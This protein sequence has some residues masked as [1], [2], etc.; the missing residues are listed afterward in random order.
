[1]ANQLGDEEQRFRL[2]A[3]VIAIADKFL[4]DSYVD[5]MMEVF[6]MTRIFRKVYE[7]AEAEGIAKGKQ[8]AIQQYLESQFGRESTDLRDKVEQI[9]DIGI[10]NSLLAKL[11]R[12]KTID[13][14][15]RLI[16]QA[17]Q[18]QNVG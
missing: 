6:K 7:E 16:H 11:Y 18:F 2:T 14:A 17:L 12:A 3:T 5:K 9:L 15:E 10:L 13:E 1:M 4:D 8:E